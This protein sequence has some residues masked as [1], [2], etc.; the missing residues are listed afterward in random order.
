MIDGGRV[1]WE[2]LPPPP[3]EGDAPV[4]RSVTINFFSD[5]PS[6]KSWFG[7][8]KGQAVLREI[9]DYL[10]TTL[11]RDAIWTANENGDW[12]KPAPKALWRSMMMRSSSQSRRAPISF[13]S[14]TM[15]R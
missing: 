8:D 10:A 1:E 12:G 6:A 2:M 5:R 14:C 3:T 7:Q 9:G 11:P 4:T 15:L 13:E